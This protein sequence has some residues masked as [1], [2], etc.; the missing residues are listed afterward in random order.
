MA[1]RWTNDLTHDDVTPKSA[2]MNRRQVMAGMAGLG[3]A[4]LAP[5]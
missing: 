4:A 5:T 2:Y 3:L 1:H